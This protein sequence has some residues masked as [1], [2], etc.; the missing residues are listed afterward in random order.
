MVSELSV[1]Q[2]REQMAIYPGNVHI[3]PGDQHIAFQKSFVL[4]CLSSISVETRQY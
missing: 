4:K 3:A 2:V 1:Q